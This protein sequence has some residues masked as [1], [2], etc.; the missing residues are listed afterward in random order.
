MNC[1]QISQVL[2]PEKLFY[3]SGIERLADGTLHVAVLTRMPGTTPQMIQWWFG[4]YME[5][6]EHYKRWHPRDHVWMAWED[7]PPGTH[8]G[9]RHLVHEYIGGRMNRL[10]IL[11]LIHI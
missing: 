4:E 11:S 8:V 1:D 6:T 3:P 9:A 10:R 5:T 7:K 2:A